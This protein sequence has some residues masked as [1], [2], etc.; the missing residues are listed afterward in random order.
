MKKPFFLGSL[1]FLSLIALYFLA[2]LLLSQSLKETVLQFQELGPW[3]VS[4]SAGFG[5][6]VGLYA[7][8]KV[9]V[10][11]QAD[12]SRG[13]LV[14]TGTTSSASM[15]VCCAHHLTD[16]LPILGFSAAS[17]FLVRYQVPLLIVSL[18]I[19]FLGIIIMARNL[20]RASS[21]A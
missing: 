14:A 9:L 20:R 12:S 2:M 1:G 5:I 15:L 13:V 8:T 6:Q 19:N 21:R 3:I 18:L 10:K 17:L 16:V 11:K 7:K 4:L